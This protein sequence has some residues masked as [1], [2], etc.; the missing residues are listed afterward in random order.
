MSKVRKK[1]N[2]SNCSFR[3]LSTLRIHHFLHHHADSQN[4]LNSYPH[5]LH[6]HAD[7]L[8]SHPITCIPTLI[9]CIP[10]IPFSNST[11]WLSKKKKDSPLSYYYITLGTKLLF[12]LSMMSSVINTK[13]CLL[14]NASSKKSVI[15]E[16]PANNYRWLKCY[17]S[18]MSNIG[19]PCLKVRT[20]SAVCTNLQKFT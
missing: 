4:F 15:C 19:T 18:F 2:R 1:D 17:L 9:L 10:L 7:S 14:Y 20:F 6:S 11:F 12:T 5:Y 8:H 3:L 13:Y 16:V